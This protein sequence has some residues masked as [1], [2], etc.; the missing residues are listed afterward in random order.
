MFTGLPKQIAY[1]DPWDLDFDMRFRALVS[2]PRRIAYYYTTPDNSTFRYRI[3]NTVQTVNAVSTDTSAG[4]F[5]QADGERLEGVVDVADVLV[6]GRVRFDNDVEGLIRRARRRGARVLFDLDD[7]V[8]DTRHVPLLMNSLNQD[9][10]PSGQWDYWYSYI[11]RMGTAL[12]LCDGVI[13]TNLFL[14]S[15]I[16][17]DTGLPA[18]IVPNYLNEEQLALSQSI[19]DV[20]QK[21]NWARTDRIHIG[22]FSGSPTHA[23]DFAIIASTLA[24]LLR[25]NPLITLRIVGMLDLHPDLS[26]LKDRIEI[27]PF[28]DFLNLQRLI[29]STEIN[30]A[31]LQDNIFTNSKSELKFFEAAA[32]ATL[33]VASPT[34]TFR[35]AINDGYTGLL[36]NELEWADKIRLAIAMIEDGRYAHVV[37]EAAKSVQNRYGSSAQWPAIERA[38]FGELVSFNSLSNEPM[39]TSIVTQRKVPRRDSILSMLK[40]DGFGLEIGPSYNPLLPKSEG[41]NVETVDYINQAGLRKKYAETLNV[42]I[43]RIEYVDHVTNGQSLSKSIPSDRSYDFILA[44]HVI[45]HTPDLISFLNDCTIFLKKKGLLV[46]AVPDKRFC[47]DLIQPLTFASEVL[48]AYDEKRTRPTPTAIM[49]SIA[50][51]VLREDAIGW[52]PQTVGKLKF[53]GHLDAAVTQ[54]ELARQSSDYVDVHCWRF[55][56]SSFRLL[57][58][59]LYNLGKIRVRESSFQHQGEHEFFIA[60]TIDG[61]GPNL[62]RNTLASMI[63]EEVAMKRI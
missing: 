1:R 51:D 25:E 56:P 60:L 39:Q 50:Y 63:A 30:L 10:G 43:D 2:R 47:F 57:I 55:V 8:Y 38:A 18:V 28:T 11:G 7:L 3:Y 24:K 29:G 52:S 26:S 23:R 12:R 22:Y 42:D 13:T 36:A 27:Y 35:N 4:W 61:P 5:C 14:A 15:Q 53:A 17:T 59:D 20:K 54:A 45:E 62:D 37:L 32:V 41:F 21:T 49:A 46:L 33:T 16:A 48:Q 40:L 31:P 9:T 19:V 34:F 6:L 58:E 44:S